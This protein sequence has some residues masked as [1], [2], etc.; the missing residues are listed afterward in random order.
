MHHCLSVDEI[1]RLLA[2]ELVASE[3]KATAAA[4]ARCCKTFEE[5]VLDVLWETQDQLAPLLKC[6]PRDVWGEGDESI[7]SPLTVFIIP[8][9]NRP[10]SRKVFKRVP[11][12]IDWIHSQKY[13]R[14]MRELRIV[15]T[16]TPDTL[17]LLHHYTTDDPWLPG[18]KTFECDQATTAFI[19]FIPLFLSPK[20]TWIDLDFAEGA[21]TVMIASVVSRLST[22]CPDLESITFF[23]LPRDSI[24]TQAVSE[25]LLACN[26]DIL[27]IFEVNSPLT[28]E[29]RE[30]VYQLPRLSELGAVIQGP[31]SLPTVALPNLTLIDV[32][33]DDDLNWL[34]GFRGTTL[35]KL[36][37]VTFRCESDRIGDFLG[38]FESVARTTSAK[39]TLSRFSFYTSSSWN[40]N[41]SA[42]LL[43][44]QLTTVEIEFSCEGGC[45][46]RVDDE[47]IV[48]LAEA[49]PKL[50]VLQLGDRPCKTPTGVTVNGLVGLAHH[51]PHLSDLCI[52][53]Q[54]AGLV[55]AATSGVT[56][57]P[58]DGPGV[59]RQGRALTVLEV[60]ATPFPMGTGSTVARM[61]LQIFPRI[62]DV[63]YASLEWMTVAEIIKDP[64]LLGGS[65]HR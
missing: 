36:D 2:Y 46:S 23:G 38:T 21:T 25:M 29:A 11:T 35:E 55:E 17:Q 57:Y 9:F 47:I 3:A 15:D 5:P 40:P 61:L 13:A 28:E 62:L 7:V 19:S 27:R 49:M 41:Y 18:L 44:N 50:E 58:S 60:G 24:I 56:L 51:C 64:G 1:L 34:Q 20:T 59:R 22:L 63:E 8:A 31:T 48:D 16:I 53:F 43:F 10:A 4:L 54:A 33:Y 6:L 39:N 52:H 42:L 26:R 30:V 45:S 14:R 12:K 37:S 32:A 65:V